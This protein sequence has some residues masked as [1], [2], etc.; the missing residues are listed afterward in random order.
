[1]IR[2]DSIV[3]NSSPRTPLAA[4]WTTYVSNPVWGRGKCDTIKIQ[5]GS[6]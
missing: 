3:N 4:K 1:L 2:G 5:I 6:F